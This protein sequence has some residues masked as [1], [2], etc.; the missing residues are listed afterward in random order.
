MRILLLDIETAPNLAYI[1]GLWN[2]NIGINQIEDNGYVL[3]WSAKWLGE[4]EIFFDS[5]KRSSE[6]SMLGKIH[7]LVSKADALVHYNGQKFDLPTLNREWLKH[8]FKPP[9]PSKHID[10]MRVCKKHFRFV[11][12]K[13][14]Y[15]SQFLGLG[16]KTHH[17][18]H[19]LWVDCMNGKRA[20]WKLME[21]Y[22]KQDVMLLESLYQELLPWISNHPSHAAREGYPCCPKCGSER[23][24][25][26]GFAVTLA[27]KYARYQCK[28]CG[29]WH[30]GN[31]NV[32]PPAKE[33]FISVAM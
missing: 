22:N 32:N 4:D 7:R 16:A 31:R 25:Q 15:V 29:G 21:E 27:Y 5:V 10:L 2:Q 33:R 19:Q 14:D 11:S 17:T 24:Q 3:C 6:K 20:A 13:L 18:G 28:D 9:A 12:N 30:R 26:R 8:G 1:W 23:Q